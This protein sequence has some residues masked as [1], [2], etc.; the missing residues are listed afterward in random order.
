[1]YLFGAFGCDLPFPL[2]F[3]AVLVKPEDVQL[4]HWT[5][6]TDKTRHDGT[7]EAAGR[8]VG[9]VQVVLIAEAAASNNLVDYRLFVDI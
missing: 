7:V 8:P 3:G 9:R 1:M 6:P 2:L 5:D 4:N